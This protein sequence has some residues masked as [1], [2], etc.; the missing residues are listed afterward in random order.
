VPKK[1]IK[2]G[3]GAGE[4]R[5]GP[6]RHTLGCPQQENRTNKLVDQDDAYE[7]QK[8][9]VSGWK[10]GKLRKPKRKRRQTQRAAKSNRNIGKRSGERRREAHVLK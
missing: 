4:W 9:W 6:L 8:Y 1:L 2:G 7:T 5:I 3:G 10:R